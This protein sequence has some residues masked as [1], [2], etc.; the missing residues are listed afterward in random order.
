MRLG[1]AISMNG[2]SAWRKGALFIFSV[3]VYAAVTA[4]AAGAT[5]NATARFL[6]GMPAEPGSPLERL[7]K[8]RFFA[9]HARYL[10]HAWN[11]LEGRQ[12]SQVKAW[13]SENLK[14]SRPVLF[15]MFSGPDFLYANAFFPHAE[16]YVMAGLELPGDIPEIE[17]LPEWSL[18]R[19]LYGLRASLNSVLS[20]SFFITKEMRSRLYGRRLTGT[21]PVLFVF[22]ARSGKTIDSVSFVQLGA[23]GTLQT[24]D[25]GAPPHAAKGVKITFSGENGEKQTL[26]YFATDLSD[27]GL[28]ESGFLSFC[29]RLGTGDALL[30]SASY[31]PHSSNFSKV[32]EFLLTR[33]ATIVEDDSGIPLKDFE[34][35]EWNV[36]PFGTY[37]KPIGKFPGRYQPGMRE[38]FLQA[39]AQPIHFSIGYRW[40]PGT[41]NILLASKKPAAGQQASST[42]PA[43]EGST[44]KE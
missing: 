44:V 21:L 14:V 33:S 41:S 30:K 32:R 12:L 34:A 5:P 24:L 22:L 20:Y 11:T 8:E 39:H 31:L 25:Q 4:I 37:M 40:R 42:P 17:A 43:K 2:N 7:T 38:L 29:E 35:K 13:S 3:A 9:E 10:D 1:K 6:A 23:D 27:T 19:E 15:Y 26:Y 28:K 36:K 16:T 18:P